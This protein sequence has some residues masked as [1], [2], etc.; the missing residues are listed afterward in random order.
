MCYPILNT[1]ETHCAHMGRKRGCWDRVVGR[2]VN[3]QEVSRQAKNGLR[4]RVL[5]LSWYYISRARSLAQ[6]R[7]RVAISSRVMTMSD[8]SKLFWR[9]AKDMVFS[10]RFNYTVC[11]RLVAFIFNSQ[12]VIGIDQSCD[13][14]RTP[15]LMKLSLPNA[16]QESQQV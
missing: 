4:S 5:T 11:N 14:K 2:S 16:E 10:N 8:P 13:A 15:T 7:Y 3:D 1:L 9:N 6:Q 12:D